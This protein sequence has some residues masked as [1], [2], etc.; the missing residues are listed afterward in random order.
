MKRAANLNKLV[1]RLV[2]FKP[3]TLKMEEGRNEIIVTVVYYPYYEI[4]IQIKQYYATV[5]T[6]YSKE[7]YYCHN[8][9]AIIKAV[10]KEMRP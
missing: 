5:K 4:K 9:R 7:I 8:V 6:N 3:R 2:K 10:Q 1:N